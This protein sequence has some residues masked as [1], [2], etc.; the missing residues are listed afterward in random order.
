MKTSNNQSTQLVKYN[1]KILQRLDILIQPKIKYSPEQLKGM[2]EA[3]YF[4]ILPLSLAKNQKVS[5]TYLL[6]NNII[7]RS[8]QNYYTKV[9]QDNKQSDKAFEVSNEIIEVNKA[10]VKDE[11]VLIDRN[12]PTINS[13]TELYFDLLEAY[14]NG[15]IRVKTSD[16]LDALRELSILNNI[17]PAPQE[18]Q[19]TEISFSLGGQE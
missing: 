1:D 4:R 8:N 18:S 19:T 16:Y 2:L 7:K 15:D 12:T 3:T 13:I 14:Q 5:L 17:I 11:I 6:D 9:V 10:L